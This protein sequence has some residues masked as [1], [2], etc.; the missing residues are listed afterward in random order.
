MSNLFA[1][2]STGKTRLK[3]IGKKKSEGQR[4]KLIMDD[5][6]PDLTWFADRPGRSAG[7]ESASQLIRDWDAFGDVNPNSALT[8]IN[9]KGKADTIIFEQ[10]KPK[11]NERKNRLVSLV[12]IH[13]E[14]E[15]DD[16]RTD[17]TSYLS[18]HA[19]NAKVGNNKRFSK[20][21]NNASLFIDGMF[22]K[23]T[24]VDINNGS[25]GEIVIQRLVSDTPD[26][27][28]VAMGVGEIIGTAAFVATCEAFTLSLAT[29]GCVVGTTAGLVDS[30]RRIVSG[31]NSAGYGPA[32]GDDTF[33]IKKM[34]D[35]EPVTRNITDINTRFGTAN[36]V[37][38]VPFFVSFVA[39]GADGSNLALPLGLF[40]FDNPII[41]HPKAT[42]SAVYEAANDGIIA[43][44][45]INPKFIYGD[46]SKGNETDHV[47]K[48]DS[49]FISK[50][51]FD[52]LDISV[53]YKG[54]KKGVSGGDSDM[55]KAWELNVLGEVPDLANYEFNSIV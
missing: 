29:A 52:S 23:W 51:I 47:T 28:D 3:P 20:R 33:K 2:G 26:W 55:V 4:Y 31:S 35:D 40:T 13:S 36:G 27:W 5:V 6:A 39:E 22:S 41:G 53:T 46:Q 12:T 8:Y 7:I 11:Y 15:L 1:L 34:S 43:S 16:H 44:S 10:E 19:H 17:N 25:N 18:E 49:K 54:D 32:G 9:S 45:S 42:F 50:K 37:A 24:S 14:Q 48:L 38:D 21:I 30:T